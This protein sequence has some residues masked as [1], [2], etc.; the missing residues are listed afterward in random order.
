[1][2]LS[3]TKKKWMKSSSV[4]ILV[5]GFGISLMFFEALQKFADSMYDDLLEYN[6]TKVPDFHSLEEIKEKFL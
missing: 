1:M 3:P 6:K 5:I 4:F 2:K